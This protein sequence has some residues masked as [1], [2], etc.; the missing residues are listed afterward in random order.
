M[1]DLNTQ[2]AP[3]KTEKAEEQKQTIQVQDQTKP[4]KGNNM[5]VEQLSCG[6]VITGKDIVINDF[7][8]KVNKLQ[9]DEIRYKEEFEK[10]RT[11]LKKLFDTEL[12]NKD[13]IISDFNFKIKEFE[14]EYTKERK[15]LKNRFNKEIRD[16]DEIISELDTKIKEFE[17]KEGQY[18][19]K[20]KLL[21]SSNMKL[22]SEDGKSK[23]K[24][25]FQI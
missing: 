11:E 13:K 18:T 6:T 17:E 5:S 20:V 22:L 8:D 9:E 19:E 21:N 10:E 1:L 4:K 15:E 3:K 23:I 12:E 25:T 16:K 2:E 24:I 14:E 7:H